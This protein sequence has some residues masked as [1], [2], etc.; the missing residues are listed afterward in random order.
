VLRIPAITTNLLWIPFKKKLSNLDGRPMQGLIDTMSRYI[1]SD[2]ANK[3]HKLQSISNTGTFG[4]FINTM[5][6]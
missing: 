6:E 3:T 5:G 1:S 2:G 4:D